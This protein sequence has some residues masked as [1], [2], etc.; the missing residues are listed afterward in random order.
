MPTFEERLARVKHLE[1]MV[2]AQEGTESARYQAE[3]AA[4]EK[5]TLTLKKAIRLGDGEDT[6]EIWTHLP[7]LAMKRIGELERQRTIAAARVQNAMNTGTDIPQ[8]N[9]DRLDEIGF[10]ILEIVTVNPIITADWLQKNRDKVA[11][12]DLL[13]VGLAFYQEMGERTRE[14]IEAQ[15]RAAAFRGDDWGTSIR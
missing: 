13:T 5:R 12:Q 7:D 3:V 1:R 11:T 9:L 10:E 15:H 14:V 6:V 2:E 8:V 4:L